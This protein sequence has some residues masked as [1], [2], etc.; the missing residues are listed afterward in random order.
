MRKYL[1]LSILLGVVVSAP[2][3]AQGTSQQRSACT[4][5]AYRF[6]EAQIPVAEDVA[7][8]LRAHYAGLS[9]ACRQE[10]ARPVGKAKRHGRRR[11]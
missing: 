3:W 2:A 7:A 8:C 11:Y 6:C 5:D 9:P 4:D 10:F 1:W